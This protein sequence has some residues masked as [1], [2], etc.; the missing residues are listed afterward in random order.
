MAYRDRRIVRKTAF[1]VVLIY[2]SLSGYMAVGM[3]RH[4]VRH[5]RIPH[6]AAQH[7]GLICHWMCAAATYLHAAGDMPEQGFL[8]AFAASAVYGEPVFS[9]KPRLALSIR[10]PPGLVYNT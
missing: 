5:G 4:A 6:N 1:L 10:P 8:F 2:L 9:N 7:A 3:E